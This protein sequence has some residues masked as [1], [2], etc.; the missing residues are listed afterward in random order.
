MYLKLGQ[1]PQR[2]KIFMIVNLRLYWFALPFK[3]RI[4]SGYGLV[5]KDTSGAVAG[6]Y[7]D[8]LIYIEYYKL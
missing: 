8:I 5:V 1:E 4:L 3:E 2:C 7:V 6:H